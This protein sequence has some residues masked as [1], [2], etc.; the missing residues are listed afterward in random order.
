MSVARRDL[1]H[2]AI[3]SPFVGF[4]PGSVE[5]NKDAYSRILQTFLN[6]SSERVAMMVDE[7]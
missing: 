6:V 3:G 4:E 7:R 2:V 5:M 1:R